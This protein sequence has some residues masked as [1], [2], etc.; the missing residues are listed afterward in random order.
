MVVLE[1]LLS[2]V[3]LQRRLEEHR[4]E[5]PQHLHTFSDYLMTTPPSRVLAVLALPSRRT[6][7]GSDWTRFIT[8]GRFRAAFSVIEELAHILTPAVLS[9][10]ILPTIIPYN[11]KAFEGMTWQTPIIRSLKS[12]GLMLFDSVR[13]R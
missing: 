1:E 3:R 4:L 2:V 7:E 13:R 10:G 5:F 12:N 6:I 11:Y 8:I 9:T